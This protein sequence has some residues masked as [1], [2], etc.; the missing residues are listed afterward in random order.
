MSTTPPIVS[1]DTGSPFNSHVE[2]VVFNENTSTA[3]LSGIKS[4]VSLYKKKISTPPAL[5]FLYGVP[6]ARV[7]PSPDIIAC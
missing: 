1:P 2:L 3:V 4:T 5:L 6:T 7:L